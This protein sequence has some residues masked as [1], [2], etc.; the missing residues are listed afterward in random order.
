MT[1]APFLKYYNLKDEV[2]IQCD[3]SEKRL[4]ATLLQNGQPVYYTSR[5]LTKTEQNYVQIEKEC[6]A[7]VYSAERFDQFIQGRKVTIM[8]D[9]KLLVPIFSKALNSAQKRLQRMLLRL[10]KYVIDLTYC[11]GKDMLIAD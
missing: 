7:I 9:H 11:P 4:G 10:Q 5:V 2:T 6:L 1:E 8:T 3:A